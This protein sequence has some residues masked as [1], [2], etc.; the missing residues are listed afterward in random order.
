MSATIMSARSVGSAMVIE[1]APHT[2]LDAG[3]VDTVRERLASAVEEGSG[4]VVLDFQSVEFASSP[5]IGMLVTL[6]LKAARTQRRLLLAG[7][8]E[9]L[10]GVLEI[11]Q[12]SQLFE[13]HKSVDEALAA[14]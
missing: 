1:F 7:L 14:L 6:R 2:N 5:A 9:N 12:M 10:A 3:T 13:I 11:M 8:R 4:G